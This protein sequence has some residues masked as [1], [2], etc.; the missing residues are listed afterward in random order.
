MPK[1]KTADLRKWEREPTAIPV[2]LVHKAD[3]HKP[4]TSSTTTDVSSTGMGIRT[5]LSLVPKQEVTIVIKGQFSRSI[6]ARVIWVKEDK[7]SNS[8]IAGLKYSV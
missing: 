4:D 2:G 3:K 8:F 5:T 6:Q 7:S 1:I